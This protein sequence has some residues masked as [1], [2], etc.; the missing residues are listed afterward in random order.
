LQGSAVALFTTIFASGQTIGPVAAGAIGDATG[1]IE[2]GLLAAGI[3]LALGAV[4]ALK[5][6]ALAAS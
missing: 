1:S 6:K 5:Q 3:V 4:I 2:G